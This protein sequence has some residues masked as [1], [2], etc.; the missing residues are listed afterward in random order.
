MLHGQ[1]MAY[2]EVYYDDNTTPDYTTPPSSN[3]ERPE[4]KFCRLGVVRSKIRFV[5]RRDRLPPSGYETGITYDSVENEFKIEDNL[6]EAIWMLFDDGDIRN[7]VFTLR[8]EHYDRGLD[9]LLFTDVIASD[10]LKPVHF[11]VRSGT[12]SASDN[13]YLMEGE[14]DVYVEV[15]IDG[16]SGYVNAD[17]ETLPEI[18]ADF[19]TPVVADQNNPQWDDYCQTAVVG[20]SIRFTVWDKDLTADDLLGEASW[21]FSAAF[22]MEN[23]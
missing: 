10:L 15:R 19:T 18:P 17:T 11:C 3:M 22:E 16:S 5:A 4:W 7:H 20:R 9:E 14:N 1:N 6:G 12:F 8:G 13:A 21:T 23:T 2:V